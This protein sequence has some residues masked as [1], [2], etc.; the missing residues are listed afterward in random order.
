MKRNHLPSHRSLE[1]TESLLD[2]SHSTNITELNQTARRRSH[3]E[4]TPNSILSPQYKSDFSYTVFTPIG[5]GK[6]PGGLNLHDFEEGDNDTQF[7]LEKQVRE[8]RRSLLH[9]RSSIR[10]VA[11]LAGS[12]PILP[13][14][15]PMRDWH[16]VAL[17]MDRIFFMIYVV[18]IVVSL[19][20]LFPRASQT[21]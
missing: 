2:G 17:V 16:D 18:L 3:K 4:A 20:V 9:M 8:I 15:G 21:S 13:L 1:S 11:T 12:P 5:G 7:H 19:V 14:E 10:D 6:R